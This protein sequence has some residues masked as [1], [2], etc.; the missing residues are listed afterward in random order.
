MSLDHE[1]FTPADVSRSPSNCLREEIIDIYFFETVCDNSAKNYIAKCQICIL[2]IYSKINC[3]SI[4]YKCFL[5]FENHALILLHRTY[6]KLYF[7]NSPKNSLVYCNVPVVTDGLSKGAPK[8][9]KVDKF[10]M[11]LFHE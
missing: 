11:W 7:L 4:F 3:T 9:V 1:K 6:M 10:N 2:L 5:A 8:V